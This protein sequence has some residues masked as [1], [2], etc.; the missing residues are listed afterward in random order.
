MRRFLFL[1]CLLAPI[2]FAAMP[3]ATPVI[4]EP[5]RNDLS[6]SAADVH[7]ATAPF[8]DG[9]GDGHRCSDWEIV[10]AG[11][12]AWTAPCV[13]SASRIHIHLGDGTFTRGRRGLGSGTA[14][15]LRVRHR[16]DSGHA[17]TEWSAWAERRFRTTPSSP[18]PPLLARDFLNDPAPRWTR[19]DGQPVEL[20]RG[21]SL[22]LE[23][24]DGE[25]LLELHENQGALTLS[26][27][28]PFATRVAVRAVLSARESAWTVPESEVSLYDDEGVEHT[29]YLPPT[30]LPPRRSC[31]SGSR[32]TARSMTPGPTI[33]RPTSCTS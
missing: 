6:Y 1:T 30:L 19:S 8:A 25:A 17:E 15:V 3:P 12:V 10:E 2:S 18:I 23:A 16:D 21:A 29:I 22:R 33:A 4:T 7:M 32:R 28:A 9:D 14:Y 26:D 27:T 5:D 31:I 11:D 24:A 13:T 20:P